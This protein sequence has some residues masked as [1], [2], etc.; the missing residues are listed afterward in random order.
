MAGKEFEKRHRHRYEANPEY[1]PR[2]EERGFRVTGISPDGNSPRSSSSTA[3]PGSSAA[4]STR[5]T[6]PRGLPRLHPLFRAF[7]AAARAHRAAVKGEATTGQT[8]HAEQPVPLA[9]NGA[10]GEPS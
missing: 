2:L 6:S 9:V 1:I 10:S 7:I 5:S 8:E 4:S 3:T